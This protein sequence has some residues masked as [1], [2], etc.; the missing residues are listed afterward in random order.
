MKKSLNRVGK[1]FN[2]FNIIVGEPEIGEG[3]WIGYFCLIDGSGGLRIG[4]HSCISSGVQIYT[5]DSIR[6]A[7]QGLEK[8]HENWTHVDRS[9]VAIGDYVFVGAGSII[10]RGTKIGNRAIIGAGSV[11]LEN[12]TVGECELWAGNPARFIKKH[13]LPLQNLP[14]KLPTKP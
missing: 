6:W 4:K 14:N 13:Q 9:S 11:I 3:T 1:E 2:D 8:D 7:V 12:T 10:L 5:H